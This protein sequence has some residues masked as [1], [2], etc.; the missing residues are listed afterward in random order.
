MKPQTIRVQLNRLGNECVA[1]CRI[2]HKRFW[3]VGRSRLEALGKLRGVLRNTEVLFDWST[4][5][6][7]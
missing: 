3:A 5:V 4:Q 7:T 1:G 2:G 6:R